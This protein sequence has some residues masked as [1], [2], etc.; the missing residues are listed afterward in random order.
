MRIKFSLSTGVVPALFKTA[1]I[2]PL[3]KQP[4]MN[5]NNTQRYRPISYLSFL[6][7]LL[8]RVVGDQIQ[9]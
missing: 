2:T 6:F 3:L 1:D 4:G 7:K 5:I 9:S 8:K